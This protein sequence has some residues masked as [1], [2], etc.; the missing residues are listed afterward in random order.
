MSRSVH[1]ASGLTFTSP[2]DGSQ[3]MMGASARVAPSER[4]SD[5][6][7][8]A[9]PGESSAQRLNLAELAA[10]LRA[11]RMGVRLGSGLRHR[12]VEPVAAPN[13]VDEG[14]RLGKVRPG[15]QEDHLDRRHHLGDQ[16]DEDDVLEGGSQH[17]GVAKGVDS[18][19]DDG[20][21]R[22][23]FESCAGHGKLV[24]THLL[25]A[26]VGLGHRSSFLFRGDRAVPGPAGGA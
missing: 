19:T 22:R 13:V 18:P 8:G 21:G 6:S 26:H 9:L 16:V 25:V 24:R 12:E 20:A 4:F 23:R 2:N 14:Q 7:H 10:V 11:A 1:V 15:V 5:V 3:P 17:D